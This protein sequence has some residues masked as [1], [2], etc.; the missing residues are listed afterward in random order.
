PELCPR[1][2]TRCM[3]L[4]QMNSN[5]QRSMSFS[6]NEWHL[7][8]EIL[9]ILSMILGNLIAITQRSMKPTAQFWSFG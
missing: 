6:S 1:A 2:S 3:P 4:P 9:A 7:L 8:L 5:G